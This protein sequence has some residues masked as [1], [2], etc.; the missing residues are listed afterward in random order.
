MS[1]IINCINHKKIYR[2]KNFLE[3]ILLKILRKS[4][5]I[6]TEGKG[7]FTS[8]FFDAFSIN[9]SNSIDTE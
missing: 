3:E 9:A 1:L 2:Y 4:G 5:K 8:V 6:N 7:C